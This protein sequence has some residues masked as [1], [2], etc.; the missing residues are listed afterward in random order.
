MSERIFE[1][2]TENRP[3]EIPKYTIPSFEEQ[4]MNIKNNKVPEEQDIKRYKVSERDVAEREVKAP[5]FADHINFA[6]D[7]TTNNRTR[8]YL[9][10]AIKI[11]SK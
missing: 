1:Y 7:L 3:P 11:E 10:K 5:T 4:L 8:K 2:D 9:D 6:K